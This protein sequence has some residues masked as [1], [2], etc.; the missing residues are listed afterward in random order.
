M[1]RKRKS[2][3]ARYYELRAEVAPLRERLAGFEANERFEELHR[4]INWSDFDT[5]QAQVTRA[6]RELFEAS[7]AYQRYQQM[8]EDRE[9]RGTGDWRLKRGDWRTP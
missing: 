8:R 5:A 1:R 4:R 2:W 7:P 6:E 3:R 9:R